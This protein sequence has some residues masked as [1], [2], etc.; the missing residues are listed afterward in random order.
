MTVNM[1]EEIKRV[2]LESVELFK[3]V[4]AI[5]FCGSLARGD[6]SLKSDIDIFI[7]IPEGLSEREAW[8]TWN[9]KL[10]E[11]LKDFERDITVLIYSL[12]SLKEIS[13]WYVLR[14]ASEGKLIFDRDGKVGRLFEKIIQTAKNAGLV[15]EEIHGHKYWIK[16]DLK[17]GETFE[18]KVSE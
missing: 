10:R 16:K 14:L 3:E 11:L 8:F 1:L 7:V 15:E 5:G 9:R 13:S 18:I 4:E 17:I 6:S 2:I 12:K